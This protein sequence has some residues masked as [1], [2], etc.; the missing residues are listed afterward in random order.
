MK[1]L[2]V[3]QHYYPE[4]FLLNEITAELVR[5]G[6]DVTA[7]VGRP[8]Y[9]EGEVLSDYRHG[10][11]K[12]QTVNGVK[13]V[14]CFEIGRGSGYFH[15][16]VNYL[17]YMISATIK[18]FFLKGDFDIVFSYQLSP[19]L[20]SIPAIVYKRRRRK[21]VFLYCCDLWPESI[22]G[23]LKN[24]RGFFYKLVARFSKYVY[25][26]V[27]V[28]TVA[29]KPFIKYMRRVNSVPASNLRYRPQF[30]SDIFLKQDLSAEDDGITDFMYAGNLGYEQDL[31]VIVK[32]A[33]LLRNRN[34]F[35]VHFV[36]FGSYL[37]TLKERVKK[38]GMDDK[39][40]F[41]GRVNFDEMGTFY[42]MAD[43]LLITLR[44]IS[45][46]G[47]TMPAKLQTYMT[48]GKPIFGAISG[49]A[50]EVIKKASCGRTVSAGDYEGLAELMK[51]Y[52]DHP[53]K[54]ADCGENA[55][56]YFKKH[57]TLAS[58]VDW[59]ENEFRQLVAGPR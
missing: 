16:A 29:S 50:E 13:V 1:I 52:I 46:I 11:N 17:S 25:N 3:C 47:K 49:A 57:F 8:N 27:D 2:V 30:A 33:G 18:A 24:S 31:D 20:M 38:E 59:L 26:T 6:H 54:Y 9:P 21:P 28:V 39:I 48:T 42:K 44:N 32:A 55:K 45:E 58:H 19:I 35:R 43:A 53:E 12:F 14:R 4:Q 34:D 56:C 5:R 10:R 40:V 37:E 22:K 51:D 41:H 36:G 15:L 23:H 7:L